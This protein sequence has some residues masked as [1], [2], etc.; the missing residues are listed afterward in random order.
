MHNNDEYL[1]LASRLAEQCAA[2]IVT[3]DKPGIGSAVKG[4]QIGFV[5]SHGQIMSVYH[6]ALAVFLK[7]EASVNAL[8]TMMRS[9]RELDRLSLEDEGFICNV[10]L[11]C[12]A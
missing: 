3:I 6:K 7:D 4:L 11:E 12:A 10:P 2:K 5:L 1:K 8:F 9:D